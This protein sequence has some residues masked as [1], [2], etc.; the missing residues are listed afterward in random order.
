VKRLPGAVTAIAFAGVLLISAA[1]ADTFTTIYKFDP[2]TGENPSGGLVMDKRGALYGV[3]HFFGAN[4]N[5]AVFRLV[6]PG[7]GQ[8]KWT[9][10][11]LYSFAGGDDGAG[12]VSGVVRST[13]GALFGTTIV[14][15]ANNAGAIYMLSP[16]G[17]SWTES[18]IYSFPS[19]DG[20]PGGR[21]LLDAQGN[22]YG[23][24]QTSVIRLTPP[25]GRQGSWTASTI[26]T[27]TADGDGR[28]PTGGLTGDSTALYG[29]TRSG[30]SGSQGIVFRLTPPGSGDG[31]WIETVLHS[32][33]GT[34]GSS[35]NGDLVV[36]GGN[37]F[38]TT[39]HGGAA[40]TG[41]VFELKKPKAG[42]S[43]WRYSM[44]YSFSGPDGD[45]PFNGLSAGKDGS[46]YGTTIQGGVIGKHGHGTVFRLSPPASGEKT[47]TEAV[48]HSFSDTDGNSPG[49]LL[50]TKSG[51]VYGNAQYGAR[52]NTG[53]TF[54][55]L[56]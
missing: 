34:E 29:T 49:L 52:G 47:W 23:A 5:G 36:K 12:P 48:L 8:S 55:I 15:G 7:A 43:E 22:L 26:C 38:G 45:L 18:V 24:S 3:L 53:N 32:F 41:T 2:A 25:A 4:G 31:P 37:L 19:S 46:L 16:S 50:I 28:G 21:L 44:I 17:G 10:N 33:S 14:G 54:E 39:E 11:I 1:R 13:S 40:D 42:Q 51:A 30:G 6:P 20:F 27:F 9:E 56:P 35:P